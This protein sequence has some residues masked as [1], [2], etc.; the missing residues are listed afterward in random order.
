M[1]AVL[2]F[3][4]T[5][6]ICEELDAG[7]RPNDGL[8]HASSHLT[9]SLRHAQ[10]DVVGAPKVESDL[11]SNLRMFTG[12]MYHTWLADT[13]RKQGI[14]FMAE[15]NLTPWMPLG[16]GGTADYL[17]LNP[18]LDA[19]VLA[20]L[21]TTKGEGMFYIKRDGAK[22]EHKWQLSMYWHAAKKMFGGTAKIA[23]VVAV[24]YLPLNDTRNKE[25]AI[26]PTLVD[27]E[28]IPLDELLAT[29]TFR[30]E[31]V[32]E[33]KS[34][35]G[36]GSVIV[37]GP[38][39]MELADFL[40]DKLAPVQERVQTLYFDRKTETYDVKLMPHW[41]AQF[42]P[43]PEELCDC[44]TQGQTKIGYYDTDGTYIARTGYEEIVPTVAP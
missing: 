32:A 11:I 9:G 22:L 14:P 30:A 40:T 42:C 1:S 38:E 15:V 18:D 8:L 12:T 4:F 36:L 17:I 19:F 6:I 23:K 3:D 35:I 34:S 21:K 10:L 44:N 33:Y 28:P 13:M 20:D 2:P 41:S 25:E 26:E 39:Q 5:E 43:F 16:W 24:L 7:R 37:R 27:F 31:A 29:A